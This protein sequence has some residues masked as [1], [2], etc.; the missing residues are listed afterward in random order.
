VIRVILR[1][2][3]RGLGKRGEIVDVSDGYARNFLLP[4]G[5]AMRS[6]A[7]TEQQAAVMRKSREVKDARDRAVA[8][9][10]AKTLAP[11]VVTVEARAS[12]EGRLFGSISANDIADAVYRQTGF[13][14]DRRTIDLDEPIKAVGTHSVPA[15]L[16]TDVQAFLQIEVVAR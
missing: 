3:V 14:I 7:G 6:S 5:L 15:R 4:Q 8:E 13:E 9:D 11:M 2:T 10:V 16:H 1:D 12:R